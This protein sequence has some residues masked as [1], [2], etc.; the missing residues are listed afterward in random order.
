M[1]KKKREGNENEKN[2]EKRKFLNGPYLSVSV[3]L[4]NMPRQRSCGMSYWHHVVSRMGC[5]TLGLK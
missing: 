5:C 4:V 1:K 3:G 2:G